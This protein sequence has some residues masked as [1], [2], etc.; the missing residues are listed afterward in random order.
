VE[1]LIDLSF[2]RYERQ[3]K[4]LLGVP[5][6]GDETARHEPRSPGC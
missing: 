2:D 1:E 3:G 4:E 6:R 5:K